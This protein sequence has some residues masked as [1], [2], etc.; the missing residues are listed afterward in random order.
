M[1]HKVPGAAVEPLLRLCLFQHKD[2]P[3]ASQKS[4]RMQSHAMSTGAALLS[5]PSCCGMSVLIPVVSAKPCH[6]GDTCT[7]RQDN[8]T[9][10]LSTCSLVKARPV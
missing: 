9:Q 6:P 1:R 8:R 7:T 5:M 2:H 4:P 3:A 10:S